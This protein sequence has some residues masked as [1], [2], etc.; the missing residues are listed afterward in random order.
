LKDLR[1]KKIVVVKR[2]SE[3]NSPKSIGDYLN[4]SQAQF[5]EENKDRLSSATLEVI[6]A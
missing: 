1:S 2:M 3:Q 4:E 5:L 6:E